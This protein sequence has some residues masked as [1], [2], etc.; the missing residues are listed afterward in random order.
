MS[1]SALILAAT[2]LTLTGGGM[3]AGYSLANRGRATGPANQP[4]AAKR[5]VINGCSRGPAF[6]FDAFC[7]AHLKTEPPFDCEAM[8][9][10]YMERYCPCYERP[11]PGGDPESH[12]SQEWT[13][14]DGQ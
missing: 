8:L 5:G 4:G 11:S 13:P 9:Q 6:D 2:V 1:K 10:E 7:A 12:P 14:D 3:L